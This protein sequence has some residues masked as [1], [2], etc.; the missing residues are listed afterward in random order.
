MKEV[1]IVG[2][3]RT[4]VGS[5]LGS[6]STVP[7]PRLGAY[8]IKA[9]IEKARVD[10]EKVDLVFMG[11]VVSAGIGQAP[12]RQASIYAGLPH[13]IPAITVSKVCGS[14][15][16]AII[17]GVR[18]IMVGDAEIV[19]AGGME[20]M[21]M[22][23]YGLP[24]A[25]TGYRMGNGEIVDLMVFDGLWD[26]YHNKHMGMF[27]ELCAEKYGFTREMQDEYAVESYERAIRATK[28]GLFKDEIV[29]VEVP[30]KEGNVIVTEDEEPKRLVKEKVSKLKPAFKPDGTIT[31]VNASSIND[32]AA[33]VVLASEEALN[34]YN[35]KPMA[36]FVSYGAF[37]Q[38]PQWFT[39]APIGAIKNALK[40][41]Q[42]TT[43]EI[44]LWE[45]NEAFAVVAMA[46]IKELELDHK[47][48]NIKGSG[49]SIGH[50][51][52]CTGARIV[53]TLIYAMRQ[54]GDRKGVAS[55]CIGGGEAL[56]TV[57]EN[58]I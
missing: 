10:K 33:A 16:E 8:A 27:A 25:R 11:N 37:A 30:S 49:C 44:D 43:G 53:V 15:M 7:A 2:A 21:S 13:S 35:L 17:Q 42:L 29:P 9:A 56:A 23:P 47:R 58:T 34:K 32:G 40:K 55:L 39:T 6:F 45:I 50:P 4:A 41:V 54:R 48:V 3:S 19:V 5:F 18:A 57:W 38:D 24:K 31:P 52:G 36:R 20:N 26:P 28:E 22:A 12:A 51:I 1:Y 46:A 14:G